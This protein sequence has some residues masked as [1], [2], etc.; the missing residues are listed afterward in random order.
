MRITIWATAGLLML[1]SA[2]NAA[3]MGRPIPYQPPAM[4]AAPNWTG[5]Y[6]GV[7]AGGGFGQDRIGF[8]VT[9]FP[10]FAT[11]DNAM[12]GFVGGGQIGYNWQF[13]SIVAGVEADFQGST[14]KGTLTAPCAPAVCVPFG[15][16]AAYSQSVPWFGTARARIGYAQ[17]SWMIYATGGYAYAAVDTNATATAGPFAANFNSESIRSGWTLGGG[18]E[19]GLAARWSVKAEYL[20]VDLGTQRTT[21]S[22]V[23]I[24]VV[25][26]DSHPTMNVVRAGLNY[27]F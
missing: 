7:N 18:V 15:L 10:A 4:V 20:Y 27:R 22:A 2:A 12:S 1:A 26:N 24:P 19:V 23:G 17:D 8:G 3:D 6:L 14:V 5:F 25:Y 16:S 21:W 11:I 13:N 9:G